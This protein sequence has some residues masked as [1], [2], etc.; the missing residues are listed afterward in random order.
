MSTSFLYRATETITENE[1]SWMVLDQRDL[2]GEFSGFRPLREGPLDNDTMAKQSFAGR[3]G[4]DLLAL[5]RITGHLKEFAA[6]SSPEGVPP[7]T[8][9]AVATV[10]HLFTD[11]DAVSRW[12]T[13]VFQ[14]EFEAA[15]GEEVAPGYRIESAE[16]FSPRGLAGETVGMDVE[17]RGPAGAASSTVIDFRVGRL[18][19]VAYAVTA[20]EPGERSPIEAVAAALERKMV[21]VVL[22]AE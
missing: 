18:L 13:E 1:L 16:A 21:R 6:T 19:G 22:R 11:G 3:T 15:I 17:Q 4:N 2:P 12:I 5:G 14:R 7:G 8:S 20:E 9:L 10:V